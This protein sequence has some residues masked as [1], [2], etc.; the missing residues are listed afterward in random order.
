MSKNFE[1]LYTISNEKGLFQP[2]D[3]REGLTEAAENAE[4]NADAQGA[5]P[6]KTSW[7]PSLPDVFRAVEDSLGPLNSF[8]QD[9]ARS[10]KLPK[11]NEEPAKKDKKDGAGPS[12]RFQNRFPMSR[13]PTT[14]LNSIPVMPAWAESGISEPGTELKLELEPE[15][16]RGVLAP[17]VFPG[18]ARTH[19]L[20]GAAVQEQ[21]PAKEEQGQRRVPAAETSRLRTPGT[22]GVDDRNKLGGRSQGRKLQARRIY[23][24]AKRELIAR[25]EDL[26]LVQRIFL[27]AEQR[28]PRMALF[29]GI[30]NEKNSAA[31][32][33]RAGEL[34]ASQAAG[35]VCLVDADFRAPSLHEYF[36]LQNDKGL[37][38]AAV[39]TGPIQEFAQQLSPAN[40]WLISSGHGAS[41]LDFAK[42]ADRLRSRM[43][44]LREAYRYVLVHSGSLWLNAN[45]MLLGKWTDGVV[46][47]L[48][49][50]ST[51]R[52]TA[53]RIKEGLAVA[54]AKVLG[55]VLNNRRYPI[56]ESLYSRL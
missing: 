50:N 7:Q 36:G 23:T 49:A 22:A 52:D 12:G 37:A 30:E 8:T 11:L 20:N 47:I 25:E 41:P 26:K 56:P 55:V 28:S 45:A 14:P 53:R 29:S 15:T 33:V 24:D 1:L 10:P 6:K 21:P 35:T 31:I 46:L 38:E 3:D 51:R 4:P 18:L 19:S 54:N 48:E 13:N 40:L 39:E 27:G 9:V 2:L 34:L 44:E 43:E 16:V 5:A 32:C 17:G 42:V